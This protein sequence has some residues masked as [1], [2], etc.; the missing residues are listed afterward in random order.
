MNDY[1]NMNEFAL[2]EEIE[3]KKRDIE[4]LRG[5]K[6][7]KEKIGKELDKVINDKQNEIDKKKIVK[8]ELIKQINEK[9]KIKEN[10]EE[11]KKN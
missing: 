11:K 6:E 4:R 1:S 8:E 2:N 5:E 7:N 10:L 3:K 9:K